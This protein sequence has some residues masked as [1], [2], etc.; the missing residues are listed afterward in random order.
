M[1]FA[2]IYYR[3]RYAYIVRDFQM[4]GMSL[5]C[6]NGTFWNSWID[7]FLLAIN[8]LELLKSIV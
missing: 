7:K 2:V 6:I 5:L 3:Q 1:I 4:G 8:V